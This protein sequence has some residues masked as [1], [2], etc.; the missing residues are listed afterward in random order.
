[1]SQLADSPVTTRSSRRRPY[2]LALAFL[3]SIA[4]CSSVGETSP[5]TT[6]PLGYPTSTEPSTTLPEAGRVVED[7][8]ASTGL[9]PSLTALDGPAWDLAGRRSEAASAQASVLDFGAVPDDGISDSAAF[10]EAVLF[11]DAEG[12]AR[13]PTSVF[14]PPGRYL[15]TE[16]LRLESG[17]ALVG[18]GIG[19]TFIDLEL[20]DG[21]EGI[22]MV[23]APTGDGT[24]IPLTEDLA[25]GE[26]RISVGQLFAKDQVVELEQDNVDRM[27][28]SPDW[29]VDW[30]EGSAGEIAVVFDSGDTAAVVSSGVFDTY[31]VARNARIR[32]ITAIRETGVEAM[33]IERLDPGYGHSIAMRFG[34]DLWVKDVE[35]IK[36]SRAHIGIDV[37]GRCEITGS[38]I[39][40]AHDY[41]DG[42]R[43]YGIS[44]ARHTTS[45][46]IE[47][48]ALWD[49]RHALIIQ[50][51][52]S[53][54]VF[55]YNDVRGSAGYED[56]QPRAD[57]SIHGHWPQANLFEGN[58]IDRIVFSD[59]WGP[60]GPNNVL[61]RG[62]VLDFAIVA[63]QSNYQAVVASVLGPDGLEIEDGIVGTMAAGNVADGEA[64]DDLIELD[65][66]AL[67]TSL[68]GATIE[69]PTVNNCRLPASEY[70]PW[71]QPGADRP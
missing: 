64:T 67:P 23:G 1:M 70:N 53:G 62:C 20:G 13:R 3:L 10:A 56:R 71:A 21:V 24:W 34:F 40:G 7:Q 60:A 42:G 8:E 69:P 41:G 68:Y 50:L 35:M 58:V 48:N 49:L 36:T 43:A 22:T 55:G 39:H 6:G 51:G 14:V 28:T 19:V 44:V 17:V 15:L 31:E 57:I 45:C 30:G 61:W 27:R 33:T 66:M 38:R 11:A 29:D 16:T 2:L 18:S 12:R 47:N 4:A 25:A 52:A 37:V 32:P 5:S 54:N 65:G 63:D 26:T 9:P 59:W 46:L